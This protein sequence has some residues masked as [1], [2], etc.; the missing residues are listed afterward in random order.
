MAGPLPLIFEASIAA[1]MMLFAGVQA[2]G[3]GR[4]GALRPVLAVATGSLG[5]AAAINLLAAIGALG[6]WRDLNL[7]LEIGCVA[8]SYVYVTG[9]YE[10]A[11]APSLRDLWHAAPPA[12]VF[13]SWK[14]G[15][16]GNVDQLTLLVLS[17]Y[18][19]ACAVAVARHWPRYRPQ[20]VLVFAL[21][22]TASVAALVVLRMGMMSDVAL[23]LSLR[24]SG[25]YLALLLV[26]AGVSSA[27]L[28]LELRHP[29]LLA[30]V[31]VAAKPA[32]AV[33]LSEVE[34]DEIDLQFRRVMRERR[35]YLDPEL[36]LDALAGQL[37]LKPRELSQFANGRYGMTV[38]AL[39]NQWRLDEA[40]RMLVDPTNKLPITTIM[41]DAGFGSK[42]SFQREFHKRFGVSPSTYRSMKGIAAK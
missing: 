31:L 8:A 33:A 13:L 12:A 2:A 37:D 7:L 24:E 20:P 6:S 9:A 19:A 3:V 18:L 17:A 40:A 32:S 30:G 4:G 14:L 28:I 27:V 36:S 5:L 26:M 38:P 35:P 34:L 1:Q 25:A 39:V 11:P 22:L 15:L 42:S 10:G 29:N 41:Y 21:L 16:V 23:G